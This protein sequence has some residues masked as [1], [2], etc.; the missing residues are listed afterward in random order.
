MG[1]FSTL[2]KQDKNG[3]KT[4]SI[5]KKAISILNPKPILNKKILKTDKILIEIRFESDDLHKKFFD[6]IVKNNIKFKFEK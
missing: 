6:D 5:I 3:D 1:T 4:L 2:I